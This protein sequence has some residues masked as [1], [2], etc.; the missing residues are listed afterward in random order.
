M[1]SKNGIKPELNFAKIEEMK[2]LETRKQLTR[3]IGYLK[4]FRPHITDLLR[5]MNKSREKLKGNKIRKFSWTQDDE[6]EL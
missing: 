3:I 6:I 4:W 2:S 5:K 1:V